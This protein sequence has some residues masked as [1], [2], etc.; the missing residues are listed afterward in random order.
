MKHIPRFYVNAHLYN[1]S[2]VVVNQTQMHHAVNVLRMQVG[3][4]IRVFNERFGEWNSIILDIKKLY[5][6]CVD[7]IV[8]P[9]KNEDEISVA[10]PIINPNRMSFLL[11]KI[12]ELGV[13][14]ILLLIS[15]YSQS[16]N[17]NINRFR[18]IV[19]GACEQCGR[20]NIPEI[21]SPIYLQD[22]LENYKSKRNLVLL[23]EVYDNTSKRLSDFFYKKC[24]FL[25]GPEGGF[26]DNERELF[27][28]YDF[29][30]KVSLGKNI[31]RTETA[32]MICVASQ[33]IL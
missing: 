16:K 4:N 3:D 18:H 21:C 2:I 5:F 8:P 22:F 32:V 12:T 30:E 24:I 13:T 9:N 14:K 15:Q 6:Q 27:K 7:L 23:D 29:I 17:F 25:V 20:I 33:T 26:S 28:K 1:G 10:F 31:L 11:E 19:I